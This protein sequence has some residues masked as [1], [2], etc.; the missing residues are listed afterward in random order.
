M[1]ISLP[2]MDGIEASGILNQDEKTKT[3]PI[4][5]LSAH[6][7]RGDEEKALVAGLIGYI[8]KP[9]DTRGFAADVG[10]FLGI[11]NEE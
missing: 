7:M 10:G 8:T 1:D 9:I 3:I 2:G 4:V 5:G 11:K 6:A